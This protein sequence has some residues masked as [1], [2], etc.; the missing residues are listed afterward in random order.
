MSNAIFVGWNRAVG[1][2]EKKAIE[3]FGEFIGWLGIQMGQGKIDSF[4]PVIIDSHGGDLNGFVLIKGK[5]DKLAAFV[6]SEEWLN[7]V[8]RGQIHMDRLGVVTARVGDEVPKMMQR[9][10]KHIANI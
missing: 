7:H 6:Q 5:P 4:E 2:R 8:V 10:G 3:H 1:G 9:F